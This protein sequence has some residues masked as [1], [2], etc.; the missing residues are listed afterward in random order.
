MA[1]FFAAFGAAF[2][3]FLAGFFAAFLD[4]LL[5]FLAGDFLAFLALDAF[6]AF[7]FFF[8]AMSFTPWFLCSTQ[9]T[10]RA[11]APMRER[12]VRSTCIFL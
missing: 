2:L 11:F 3:A 1:A 7:F 8:A 12:C 4:F 10:L 6:F 9:K 5:D